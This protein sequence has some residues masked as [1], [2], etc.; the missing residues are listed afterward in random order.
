RA[1]VEAGQR[2]RVRVVTSSRGVDSGVSVPLHFLFPTRGVRVVP[3]SLAPR[4]AVEC[5]AW[6][7]CL[8]RALAAW[9]ER[10]AVVVG[11]LLS[12]NRHAW[13]LGLGVPTAPP[14]DEASPAAL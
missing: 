6:G 1:L 5:R 7:E 4:P 8:R 3:V 2:A 10:V 13:N 9:P 12:N 11:G 14:F